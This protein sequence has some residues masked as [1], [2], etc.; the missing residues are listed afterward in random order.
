M[1]F[2]SSGSATAA[3]WA[4]WYS[5]P[6]GFAVN[7]LTFDATGNRLLW[8]D[9]S[10]PPVNTRIQASATNGVTAT[11]TSVISTLAVKVDGLQINSV[12]NLLAIDATTGAKLINLGTGALGTV[13]NL[14]DGA[15]CRTTVAIYKVDA[16]CSDSVGKVIRLVGAGNL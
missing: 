1:L 3:D 5:A 2:R 4:T 14:T 9:N 8:A 12:G 15:A 13:T 16:W 11:A 7:G 6:A 10:T